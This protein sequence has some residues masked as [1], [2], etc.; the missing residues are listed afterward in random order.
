MS[1]SDILKGI[2]ISLSARQISQFERYAE[3]LVEWNQKINLTAI[4]DMEDIYV[5]HFYDSLLLEFF[6]HP[7]ESLCDVG[8]GAGFPGLPLALHNDAIQITL[9]EPIEKKCLFLRTAVEQ[10]GLNNVEVLNVRAES[11]KEKL[12]KYVVSRAVAPLNILS[13]LCLPLVDV[14]GHFIAMKGPKAFE[15]AE[16]A[17]KGIEILGGQIDSMHEA[18]LP[19]GQT[20]ICIDIVKLKPTAS[21][22]PRLYSKIKKNPL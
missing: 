3:L 1:L 13:E 9:M 15:E 21:K 7:Q 16:E 20:R 17:R 12:F 4:T 14:N 19:N 6:F 22:Y 8:S 10:L 11:Y 18:R 2:N 5:K